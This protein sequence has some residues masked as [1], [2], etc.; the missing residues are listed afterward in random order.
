MTIK[1][2]DVYVFGKDVAW[3]AA[4][5]GVRRRILGYDDHLMMIAVDFEKGSIGPV[6]KHPHRQVTYIESGSF[7]VLIGGQKKIQ[8]RGDCYFIPPNIEH[9]VIALESSS[10]VDVFTPVREDIL[11]SRKM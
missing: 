7:E 3:E 2:T 1:P 10:L 8:R 4:G 9:G 5:P 6:H 11:E